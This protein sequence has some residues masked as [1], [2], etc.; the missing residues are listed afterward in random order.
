MNEDKDRD[1]T[2]LDTN[3]EDIKANEDKTQ[4]EEK[5]QAN[6]EEVEAQ[7]QNDNSTEAED[8]TVT[9]WGISKRMRNIVIGFVAYGLI[10]TVVP[11]LFPERF[12]DSN[13]TEATQQAETD[14]QTTTTES[15][16]Q[17]S[18]TTT[19]IDKWLDNASAQERFNLYS[20][21]VFHDDHI[22]TTVDFD[23]ENPVY[24]EDGEL[25]EDK[26][27]ISYVNVQTDSGKYEKEETLVREFL[28]NCN[29]YLK[30]IKNE[31]FDRVFIGAKAM[32][33]DKDGNEKEIYAIKFEIPKSAVDK[34]DFS[35]FSYKDLPDI[36]SLFWLNLELEV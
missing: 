33:E 8:D 23:S 24:D 19:D 7:D 26:T 3:S 9:R 20:E 31:N 25:D 15:Y 30:L 4:S 34:I 14:E 1:K 36:A 6:L 11:K 22:S 2:E 18:V 32:E 29:D 35:N 10:V 12:G 21:A 13:T 16:E 27:I 17:T 5:E 28:R